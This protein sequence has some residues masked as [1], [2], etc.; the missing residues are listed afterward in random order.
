MG[1]SSDAT[2]R[3]PWMSSGPSMYREPAERM[4]MDLFS[5][6]REAGHYLGERRFL[7]AIALSS[8]AVELILNR[9]RRMRALPEIAHAP[10][11]WANLNNRNLR[12][13]REKGLPTNALMS[14]VDDLDSDIPVAFVELRN[15]VA[16]GEIAHL[17]TTL[18]D[19]DPSAAGLAAD[20]ESKMRKFVSEWFNT[21]PDVQEGHIR[22]NR[23]PISD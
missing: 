17:V 1:D 18:S 11:G 7:A 19:Y 4:P 16:H 13:A 20:Q 6:T 22:E 14:Q 12:I 10:H 23:W 8:T 15:K 5:Y 9:D 3:K 21:A 2:E